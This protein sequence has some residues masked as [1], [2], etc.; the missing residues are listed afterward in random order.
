MRHADVP[1]D[2]LG[3]QNRLGKLPERRG[4]RDRHSRT[5]P[6]VR[7]RQTARRLYAR[8]VNDKRHY[9]PYSWG[10]LNQFS[11]G[12]FWSNPGALI[13]PQYAWGTIFAAAQARTLG[14]GTV[15]ILE[16]GVAGGR[17]LLALQDIAT[18]VS[19]KMGVK[20]YV[21][22][23]DTGAGLPE[24]TDVRDLPQLYKRGDYRMDFT[25]LK[26]RL[27]PETQLLLGNVRETLDAF[28]AVSHARVGFVSLDLDLYTSTR[29]AM[30]LFRD[31]VPLTHCL[32]RVVCY[33]DDIMGV[34]FCDLTG[35]R[36]AISEYNEA[37]RPRRCVSPVY[38]LRYRLGWPHNRAQW[39][40]MMFWAHF[41]DHPQYACYDG[42]APHAQAKL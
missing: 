14:Y 19:A 33:L 34:T 36:L 29:D 15:A 25:E 10:W 2:E 26:A 24:V 17:G 4:E 41:L 7:L 35:E 6:R 38:G 42:L 40:D 20:C 5:I 37:H 1:D 12:L 11:E 39:P 23:F 30:K 21:Y 9:P 16:F 13:R 27:Q 28:L 32:P 31:A 18:D 22:G 8:V 3:A